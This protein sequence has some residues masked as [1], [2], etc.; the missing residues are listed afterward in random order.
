MTAKDRSRYAPKSKPCSLCKIEQPIENFARDVQKK[1]GHS[2][3]CRT[4]SKFRS[5]NPGMSIAEVKHALTG[6]SKPAKSFEPLAPEEQVPWTPEE[7][8]LDC[9]GAAD[10]LPLPKGRWRKPLTREQKD[11]RNARLRAKRAAAKK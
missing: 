4:C 1:D 11:A 6:G 5:A 8:A 7:G 2:T 9:E 3:W 10:P